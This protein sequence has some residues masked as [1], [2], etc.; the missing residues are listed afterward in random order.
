MSEQRLLVGKVKSAIRYPVKSM[1]GES[2]DLVKL[3]WHG[4]QDDRRYAIVKKEGLSGFPWVTARDWP[5]II[6]YE[7]SIS[8]AD[9][10]AQPVILVRTPSG[11]KLPI[12]SP[13]LI[14]EI[15]KRSGF[16]CLVLH[17]FG[18]VFDCSDVSIITTTT[19]KGLSEKVGTTLDLRRFRANIVI[20][21][22]DDKPFP[23]DKWVGDLLI[24]GESGDLARVRVHR[25]DQRC[26]V[27]NLDPETAKQD[28]KVLKEIVSGRK[29]LA[30]I[31]G[32]AERPGLIGVG[33]P[34][35]LQK[36]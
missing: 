29:N 22:P 26:M 16:P 18:G 24:F 10:Q 12:N 14:E 32:A 6:L 23:E 8:Q 31:Y 7:P 25:K 5:E 36:N 33:D 11:I 30:G 2:L 9:A 1:A 3:G 21:T 4:L 27:V 28:P 19:L 20:E 17:H 35:W 15:A 34:V 13:E